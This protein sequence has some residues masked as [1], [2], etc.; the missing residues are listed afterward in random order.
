MDYSNKN[1]SDELEQR[2]KI[3][4]LRQEVLVK[5]LTKEA[6]ERLGN[7]RYAHPEL[8]EDIENMLFC[9]AG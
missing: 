9:K 1:N 2:K 8:A 7:L 5:Y 4:Q 3:E 6:R